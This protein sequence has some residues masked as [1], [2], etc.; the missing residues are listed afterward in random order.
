VEYFGRNSF[1]MTILQ[2]KTT[3]KSLIAGYLR[4]GNRGVPPAGWANATCPP[5]RPCLNQAEAPYA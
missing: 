2:T 1:I 4:A 5:R 3:R